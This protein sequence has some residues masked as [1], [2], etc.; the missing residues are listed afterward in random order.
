MKKLS[1][2]TV[3]L[4]LLTSAS[5]DIDIHAQS[6]NST[7]DFQIVESVPQ[8]TIYGEPGVPRT[9]DVWLEMVKGAKLSI[10]IAAFYITDQKGSLFTPVLDALVEQA[11]AGVKI[12]LLVDET[13]LKNDHAEVDRLKSISGIE[14]RVLPVDKLTGGVLHAKYMIVDGETV[15]VG[16]QNWDWRALDQIHEVGARIRDTRFAQTFTAVFDFDWN[17]AAHPDLPKAAEAA[18]RPPTF[19]PATAEDPVLL[20][21]STPEPL[22]AFPAFSPPALIPA[23]VSSEEPSLVSMIHAAKHDLRIQVMTF[24]AI[25]QYGPK[26]W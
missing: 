2:T 6:A 9:G 16:S 1:F 17:L 22:F 3:L 15:F 5:M 18:I 19:A 4:V 10:D 20:N 12:H 14:V 7:P 23:W 24:S 25:R 26:G 8:A 11:G 21:R 13:F